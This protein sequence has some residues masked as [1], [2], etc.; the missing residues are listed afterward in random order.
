LRRRVE[1]PCA[2]EDKGKRL[3][4]RLACVHQRHDGMQ[5]LAY[6]LLN[7]RAFCGPYN[8]QPVKF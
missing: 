5:L 3:L 7:V 2:W 4:R 1:C 8:L 6:T